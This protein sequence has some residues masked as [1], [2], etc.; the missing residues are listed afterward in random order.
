MIALY[1]IAQDYRAAADKLAD[2][3]LPPEVVADTLE[4]LS[5]DLEVKAQSVA[6]MVRNLEV[7]AEAIKAFEKQQK[8]R[9][10][11]I[12]HRAEHL[13]GYLAR[14][15]EACGIEKVEGP[16]IAIGWRKSS[17]VVIDEPALLPGE[18]M[19]QPEPPP[20]A[21]DKA[22]IAAAIKAGREVPGA[23]VEHRRN[24]QIR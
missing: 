22:S 11:A 23:H 18:F 12:E 5:G 9:R 7:T 2:L 15:L 16:G 8:E 4:S 14:T 6:F 3:D 10:E 17:A 13:R 19:R 24:L 1:V 20:P 21:P